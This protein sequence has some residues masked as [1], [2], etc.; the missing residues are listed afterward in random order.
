MYR[1]TTSTGYYLV[2]CRFCQAKQQPSVTQ[3]L[4]LTDAMAVADAMP[5]GELEV[6]KHN[7]QDN[8]IQTEQGPEVRQI[9]ARHV[10]PCEV[11]SIYFKALV[12][13]CTNQNTI[14]RQ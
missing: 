1:S 14:Y 5:S 7:C 10:L 3:C 11:K 6:H 13:T 8:F 9:I 12:H 2:T 4:S